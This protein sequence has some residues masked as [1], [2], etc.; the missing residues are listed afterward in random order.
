MN[1]GL[2]MRWLGRRGLVGLVVMNELMGIVLAFVTV[3][4]D[5]IE[6]WC[7]DTWITGICLCSY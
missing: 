2:R 6:K 3:E 1:G 7:F 5:D 4:F